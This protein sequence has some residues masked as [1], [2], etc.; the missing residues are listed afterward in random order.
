MITNRCYQ[1]MLDELEGLIVAWMF[2]LSKVHKVYASHMP[3][4][5][6][7]MS[8]LG[9]MDRNKSFSCS[10]QANKKSGS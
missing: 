1:H 3:P 2:E 7:H 6:C 4:T 5:S 10:K 8:K 9:K